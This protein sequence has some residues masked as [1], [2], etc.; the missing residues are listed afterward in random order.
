MGNWEETLV[1]VSSCDECKRPWMSGFKL[2][3]KIFTFILN[4]SY[5]IENIECDLCK[6]DMSKLKCVYTWKEIHQLE[7]MPNFQ[8]K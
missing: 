4:V 8:I 1:G 3:H 6:T 2:F 7:P 5:H